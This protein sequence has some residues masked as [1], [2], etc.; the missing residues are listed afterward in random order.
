MTLVRGG[1][2]VAHKLPG[3]PGSFL[4]SQMLRQ[5]QK[6]YLHPTQAGQHDSSVVY[7][8]PGGDSISPADRVGQT[9][10]SSGVSREILL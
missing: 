5:G 2:E 1:T 4:G 9:N 10:S 7:K 6:Q 8:Q 3:D